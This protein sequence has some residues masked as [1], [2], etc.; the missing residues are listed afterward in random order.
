MDAVSTGLGLGCSPIYDDAFQH[1]KAKRHE[2]I[3]KR[4]PSLFVQFL[5]KLVVAVA[6]YYSR[7]C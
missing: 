1:H 3:N 5:S 2:R 6:Y 4:F 7:L